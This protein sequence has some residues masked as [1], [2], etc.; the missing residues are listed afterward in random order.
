MISLV[1]CPLCSQ[2][3]KPFHG[4]TALSEKVLASWADKMLKG[5][6]LKHSRPS[7]FFL[8]IN[9]N[10]SFNPYYIIEL[11][12]RENPLEQLLIKHCIIW[13]F[14]FLPLLP[15]SNPGGSDL[16]LITAQAVSQVLAA[17]INLLQL[18]K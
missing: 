13:N 2:L 7:I 9:I 12:E 1:I 5:N 3:T 14:T 16:A 18:P 4:T 11:V 10:R 6:Q 8:N 15:A 17:I